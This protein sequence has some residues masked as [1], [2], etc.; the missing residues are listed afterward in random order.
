MEL[1]ISVPVFTV[2]TEWDC[3]GNGVQTHPG[4][5]GPL[6]TRGSPASNQ[7]PAI[8]QLTFPSCMVHKELKHE[9]SICPM[10]FTFR[11]TTCS[12]CGDWPTW[13]C[14]LPRS[15]WRHSQTWG[16]HRSDAV[17]RSLSQS[18]ALGTSEEGM[19]H[20]LASENHLRELQWSVLKSSILLICISRK[21]YVLVAFHLYTSLDIFIHQH[22]T[23]CPFYLCILKVRNGEIVFWSPL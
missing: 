23:G 8:G 5:W 22:V 4:W 13:C 16:W 2:W 3:V 14:V 21:I 18:T 20:A 12:K 7:G 9:C 19:V 6:E 1:M 17:D 15:K 11:K 10:I